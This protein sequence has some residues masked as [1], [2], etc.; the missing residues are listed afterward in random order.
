MR[1][2]NLV[3][4]LA[5]VA[6]ARQHTQEPRLRETAQALALHAQPAID[7][8]IVCHRRWEAQD[9]IHDGPPD[10]APGVS[11]NADLANRAAA[12]PR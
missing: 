12:D 4:Q 10:R 9:V 2:S 6:A 3:H 5:H 7:R 1:Q 11:D 8:R